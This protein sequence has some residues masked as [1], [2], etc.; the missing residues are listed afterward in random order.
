MECSIPFDAIINTDIECFLE[1]IDHAS[2]SG[3]D[4]LVPQLFSVLREACE[5]SGQVVDCKGEPFSFELVLK[6]LEKIEITFDK[7]GSP[8]MPTMFVHPSMIKVLE[9]NMPTEDQKNQMDQL[10]ARKKD[11][12][13]AKKRTRKL[14]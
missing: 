1:T 5:E 14:Y 9:E 4:S 3:V 10:I 7:D 13:F 6:L 2:N 12:Y 8:S 11:E